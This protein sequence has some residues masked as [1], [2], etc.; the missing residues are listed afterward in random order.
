[1][2]EI[3]EHKALNFR[4]PRQRQLDSDRL[5]PDMNETVDV[6]EWPGMEENSVGVPVHVV[7]GTAAAKQS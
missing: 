1:M 3:I 7:P 5:G 4:G 2:K 6:G